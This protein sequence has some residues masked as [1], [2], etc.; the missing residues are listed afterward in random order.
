MTTIKAEVIADT[1]SG[2]GGPAESRLTTLQLRYPR[3]I[4]SEFMTHR[5]FSRNA[6]SSRAVP[7]KKLIED[8]LKN[9][10]VPLFWGKNKA[11]MQAGGE[12]NQEVITG[13]GSDDYTFGSNEEAWLLAR[14]DAVKWANNFADAGYHKQI[15]N[16]LIEPFS[17]INVV[18]TATEWENFFHLRIHPDAEPHMNALALAIKAAIDLSTPVEDKL[19]LPYILQEEK[20]YAP[21]EDVIMVS[22][23][24]C[25]RVS[26]MTHDNKEPDWDQDL[27]LSKKLRADPPHFSPFEHQAEHIHDGARWYANFYRWRS[28]RFCIEH[29]YYFFGR[30]HIL[31]VD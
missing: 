23:A 26:Y 18:V 1:I 24:R 6:S 31:P 15:A 19:H 8:V 25:A 29:G 28:L 13:F 3:F 21:F 7:V 4:H 20:V 11:G 10:A 30:T 9:P 16:R 2:K 5:A 17:H 22:S 27:A 12:H 14:D